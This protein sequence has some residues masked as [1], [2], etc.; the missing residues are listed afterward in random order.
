MF[1]P[2]LFT[3]ALVATA[4]ATKLYVSS[5]TGTIT[6][7]GLT[8]KNG[9]YNLAKLNSDNNCQPN[10]TWLQL[11]TKHQNLYC[12]DENIVGTNGSIT[13]FKIGDDSGKLTLLNHTKT[14]AAPVNSVMYTSPNRTQLIALAHYATALAT[15]KVDPSTGRFTPHQ[16]FNF[17]LPKPGPKADRQAASHPHQVLVDPQNKYLV[18]P[19][20]GGDVI[21]IFYVDPVTLSITPRPSI[22]LAP[23][24]GPRHGLFHS[25]SNTTF[26]YLVTELSNTLTSYKTTYLPQNGGLNFTS[27]SSSPS[28]GTGNSKTFA[29]N[30][31]AE[32][33][34]AHNGKTLV[35]S[36][37]NATFQT[38]PN[39]DPK[40]ATQVPS[41]A[42]A[43]FS[44]QPDSGK[45]TFQELT[46][47][48]GSFPRHFSLNAD[49]SLVAVVLQNS[50]RV[51]VYRMCTEKG[52]LKER[53]ADYE[54]LGQVTSVVWGS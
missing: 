21:R 10:A 24:S 36:N 3:T 19:D 54:G 9:T 18:V 20:L 12:L 28:Y 29:F 17:T 33:A 34:L 30:A 16:T 46:P 43:T 37:R 48:G 51:V 44:L 42:M 32:V 41:D 7:L 40:N 35:V 26:Y 27:V 15:Y 8:D 1:L 14:L 5:Y 47:A 23:D 38:I 50:G 49:G 2:I 11:D 4:S 13:S 25:S 6:T 31:A 22:P 52:G 45:F 39:P 53:V